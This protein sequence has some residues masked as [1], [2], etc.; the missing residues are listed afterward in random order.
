MGCNLL[1]LVL[2]LL[3]RVLKVAAVSEYSDAVLAG[4]Q[5]IKKIFEICHS[6]TGVARDWFRC[7]VS[8]DLEMEIFE[9]LCVDAVW[10]LQKITQVTI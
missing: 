8:R 4:N 7:C 6:Y 3:R 10:G 9:G 5:N 1:P 2:I